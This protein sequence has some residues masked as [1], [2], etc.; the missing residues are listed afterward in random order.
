MTTTIS[1]KHETMLQ[2]ARRKIDQVKMHQIIMSSPMGW[3]ER[4]KLI[5]DMLTTAEILLCNVVCMHDRDDDGARD[6]RAQ[7]EAELRHL[8]PQAEQVE[9]KAES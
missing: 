1:K 8:L 2:N 3:T 4:Q 7:L 9:G 5:F 6:I